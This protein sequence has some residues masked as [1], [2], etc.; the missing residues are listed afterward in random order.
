MLSPIAA[1][2]A[3]AKEAPCGCGGSASDEAIA[4]E[5]AERRADELISV[6][7]AP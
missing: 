1:A 7:E 3:S 6:D 4:E 2:G 5:V